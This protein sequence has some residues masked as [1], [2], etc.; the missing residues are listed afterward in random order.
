[1]VVIV[2]RFFFL[3]VAHWSFCFFIVGEFFFALVKED[4]GCEIIL[5]PSKTRLMMFKDEAW[6]GETPANEKRGRLL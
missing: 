2:K 3:G 6:A 5:D 1:M 4:R